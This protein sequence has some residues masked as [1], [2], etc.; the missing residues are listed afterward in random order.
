MAQKLIHRRDAEIAEKIL[1]EV[2]S[3]ISAS[4]KKQNGACWK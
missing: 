4:P 2:F 3:A 1:P